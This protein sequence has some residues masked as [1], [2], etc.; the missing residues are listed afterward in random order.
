MENSARKLCGAFV[1][2][3]GLSVVVGAGTYAVRIVEKPYEPTN[4]ATTTVEFLNDPASKALV[5]HCKAKVQ[6][7]E[8]C[9]ATEVKLLQIEAANQAAFSDAALLG[10]PVGLTLTLA[11]VALFAGSRKQKPAAPK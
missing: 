9:T 8:G 7:G 11:G 4:F 2:A 6:K 1:T 10:G 5:D 3:V